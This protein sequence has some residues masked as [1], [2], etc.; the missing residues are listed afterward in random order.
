MSLITINESLKQAVEAASGGAQ[1]VLVTPKG[2][3][4]YMNVINKFDLSTIDSSMAGTH[5]AFI[6][7]GVEKDKI[8]IGTYQGVIK[9]GELLSLPNSDIS[10]SQSLNTNLTAVRALGGG[11]HLMTAAEWGA[12]SMLA[13]QAGKEVQGN[14]YY[15]RSGLDA[16]QYGRRVDGQSATAGINNTNGVGGNRIY[17][18]SGP[19]SFR[20]NNKYNGISDLVGNS[21]DF[22][23][24]MRVVNTELQIFAN[25][26]A[27]LS[28]ADLLAGGAWKAIDGATGNL[29]NP[30]GSGTTQGSVRLTITTIP[31]SAAPYSLILATN[32]QTVLSVANTS[33]TPIP[34]V[35]L[36]KLKALGMLTLN[37]NVQRG[38]YVLNPSQNITG[39]AQRGGG[40]NESGSG[41]FQL[42]LLTV[43]S[44]LSIG[45][46]TV[47]PCYYAP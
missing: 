40:P 27:A 9:N 17:A 43:I 16:T 36:N 14:T 23:A 39:Y 38:Y 29:V 24:G 13:S 2:Q 6:V 42:S 18:G 25:N 35:T 22:V 10:V 3:L 12:L 20:H 19:V 5:P 11:H 26:D 41:V 37:T 47:R 46:G 32:S 44:S 15:G 45:A 33:P 28:T 7:N 4:T 34:A 30:D 31:G 1:T 21:A 8:Y